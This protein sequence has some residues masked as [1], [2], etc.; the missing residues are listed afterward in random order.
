MGRA[1]RRPAPGAHASH[2]DVAPRPH[3][4]NRIQ[5]VVMRE[6]IRVLGWVVL[7]AVVAACAPSD[8]R[9]A[10]TAES[11]PP[12]STARTASP[13]DSPS[14]GPSSAFTCP[15]VTGTSATDFQSDI[16]LGDESQGIASDWI[17]GLARLYASDPATDPCDFFAGDALARAIELDDRL[18]GALD[19][20]SRTDAQLIPRVA[21]EGAYDL[22]VAPP[23]VPLTVVWDVPAGSA[24][25]DLLTGDIV[26]LHAPERH[27]LLLTFVLDGDRWRVTDVRPPS[28]DDARWA[29]APTPL[30]SPP[31]CTG[32]RP[33][34]P[35]SVFDEDAG[36][37]W[38]NLRDGTLV[39][40]PDQLSMLTR[41]PCEHGRVAVLIIGDPLG[42]ALDALN[43]H[44]YLRD[45]GGTARS[46]GW[47][48]RP[49]RAHDE[50]PADARATGWSNG[51]IE[52]WI[53]PSS[54]E[55]FV[56]VKRGDVLERW[57]RADP[58]GWGVMD[59]N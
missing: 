5:G 31:A 12:P 33:D 25:T 58:D 57:P 52:L 34:T 36:R 13:S 45:P 38:C 10:A 42:A 59:C 41:Y 51:N 23:S 15:P 1:R 43:R 40:R 32:L 8:V 50:P 28:G 2:P 39:R 29:V 53:S 22:R 21:F 37:P 30:P 7:T 35:R 18:R 27:G 49:W 14:P 9:P 47:I 3:P 4:T 56:W 16:F 44:E 54:V 46:Q 24:T 11:F 19:G 55:D 48:D 6:P 26:R 20:T 17:A